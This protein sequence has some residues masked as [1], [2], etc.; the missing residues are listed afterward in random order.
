[1]M[2]TH[3]CGDLRAADAGHE[4]RITGWVHHR[5]DHGKVIFID[6]RDTSGTVQVV[7]HPEEQPGAY[8]VADSLQREFCA[9]VTGN[10]G[11][12]PS[13]TIN[14]KLPTGEIEIKASSVEILSTS[15]TPPFLI[16]DGVDA[17][18][19]LRLKHRYLDLRRPE[20]QRNIRLRAKVVKA[21][22]DYLDARDFIEIETPVLTRSTPEGARDF[23]VPSRLQPGTFFA[24]PQS[25]QLY[26]QLLMVAGLERYY[27]IPHCFRD[28][29]L[30]ADRAL[31]FSQLDLE[32]SFVDEDDVLDVT[33][34]LFVSLWHDVL[35]VEIERPFPRISH[36]ESL[37]RFGNDKPD[38]RFGMELADV[39][40][41][42]AGTSLGIIKRVLD[43][44]GVAQA[45]LV[46]GAG[47]MHHSELRKLEHQ[48]MDRGAKGLA[49]FAFKEGGDV[50][51]PL[52]KHL[53]PAEREGLIKTLGASAGDL[54]L[55]VAD[56]RSVAQTVLGSLRGMLARERGLIPE[57]EWRFCWIVDPPLFEWSEED[58]RWAPSH[59]PFTQ[60]QPGW[61]EAMAADPGSARARAYDIVLNGVEL[62]SGS[63]RIHDRA[64][65]QKVLDALGIDA[66]QAQ[67]RFGFLLD[68]FRFG[69]PPHGGIAPGIDRIVMLM[70]GTDNIREV[71]A[72]PK[73]ASGNDPLTGAPTP[74]DQA[75]LDELGLRLRPM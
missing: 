64:M 6:L 32:M 29:D 11:L 34:G 48:A 3:R 36:A 31:E 72:F 62:A 39:A 59:H 23:L 57:G 56:R 30:R 51:S 15:E 13:G 35:G 46:P 73:A 14:E 38:L 53:S 25:P 42:F 61:E 43:S 75:Q 16:E 27:Q 2:R 47:T 45:I 7:F 41:V 26:K 71:T 54:G 74:V 68:A 28:E 52:A 50:D 66:A 21:I 44:G 33:E 22:R 60:P 37:R 1:M 17:S 70:A 8:A 18:E 19:D 12:R 67:A 4:V 9:L 40:P 5:R 58:R 55:M 24:L 65:Q 69:P 20:M 10:V 49:W 63:V